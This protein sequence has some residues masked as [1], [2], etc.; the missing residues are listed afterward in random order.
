[1]GT[2]CTFKL[3]SK[4]P[5]IYVVFKIYKV[6]SGS[7]HIMARRT[8]EYWSAFP[9]FASEQ[10]PSIVDTIYFAKSAQTDDLLCESLRD[11]KEVGLLVFIYF[12]ES[13]TR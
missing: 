8:L 13:D 6:T 1:M 4:S 10:L 9:L 2:M 5:S 11:M 7:S 12:R 3:T